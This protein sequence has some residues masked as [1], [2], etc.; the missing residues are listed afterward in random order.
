M[1]LNKQNPLYRLAYIAIV[2]LL[3]ACAS[4]PSIEIQQPDWEINGKL[5]VREP[6]RNTT[7]LFHWQQKKDHYVIH[8]MNPLGQIQLSLVGNKRYASAIDNKGQHY[9]S[10]NAEQLL[11]N[12]T[13]WHFPIQSAPYW[14]QGKADTFATQV[15]YD[16]QQLSELKSL[17]WRVAFSR[18]RNV[19]DQALPHRILIEQEDGLLTLT[20]IIKQHAH[21]IP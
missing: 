5:A 1:L 19:D 6:T 15:I 9:Q 12:L 21:F 11:Y 20:L 16:K 14:L 3:S 2:L 13:G 7:M 17:A 8:L 10:K 4:K 18:Y